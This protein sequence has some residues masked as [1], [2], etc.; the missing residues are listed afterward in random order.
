ME[1]QAYIDLLDRN[2][3]G[4]KQKIPFSSALE[5]GNEIDRRIALMRRRKK[6]GHREKAM[7]IGVFAFL[8]FLNSLT[9]LAY[10]KIYH[11]K[12]TMIEVAKDSMD[13]GNFWIYDYAKDGYGTYTD[14]VLYNE[15]FVDKDGHIYQVASKKSKRRVLNMKSYLALFKY[16]KKI[17][18]GVL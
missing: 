7:A 5:G 1:C 15:Q 10:P 2:R 8:V 18:K 13:G 9:A 16:I 3:S 12:E 11:V 6:I 17:A 14:A 4:G